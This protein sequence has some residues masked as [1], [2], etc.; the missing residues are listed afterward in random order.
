MIVGAA[1]SRAIWARRLRPAGRWRISAGAIRPVRLHQWHPAR[2]R[3]T[4]VS[5]LHV[6]QQ[7]RQQLGDPWVAGMLKRDPGVRHLPGDLHSRQHRP[8]AGRA[9][10]GNLVPG[11]RRP[12]PLD[13]GRPLDHQRGLDVPAEQHRRVV[14]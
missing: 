4:G 14:P 7:L 11:Q 6:D 10:E 8:A 3:V 13:L 12:D 2:H 9:T 5:A 1:G